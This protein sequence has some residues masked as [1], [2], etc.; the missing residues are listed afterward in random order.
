MLPALFFASLS[1]LCCLLLLYPYLVYPLL[2]AR[3]P[4]REVALRPV[5]LQFSLLFCVFNEKASIAGKI[6][7]LRELKART[8][9]LQILVYDDGSSDG[10]AEV[11]DQAKDVV[12]LVR[13]EGRRGK[14]AGMRRLA[15]LAVGEILVFTDA[16][17]L[18]RPDVIEC[19]APYYGDAG[20]GG[21]CGTL[22]YE[23]EEWSPTAEIGAHYW[24]IDERLRSLESATGN[25]MGADGSIFS[26]RRGLYPTFPD[27]VLD[28][29]VTSMSVVFAGKRL[30]KAPDVIA[31]EQS[32]ARADEEFR[33]KIRIG[34]R[35]AHTHRWMREHLRTMSRLDRFKYAS[36]KFLRWFGG[37][38]LAASIANSLV[39]IA[40][41]SV[42]ASAI[43]ALA[44]LLSLAIILT[45]KNGPLA[46]VGEIL[47]ALIATQIG[48]LRGMRGQTVVTWA[49]AV[50]R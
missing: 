41:V 35:A 36:R 42:L 17:V 21:V 11:L 31:F 3:Y 19:L 13:G 37:G 33:R 26:I 1:M 50:S 28:D 48:V 14:A 23:N 20:V 38:F 49:P 46:K 7:N 10:T 12:T 40:F 25:V 2:L 44:S 9:N 24:S 29:F 39:A 6:A 34:T 43:A 15:S 32:V 22:R 8:P 18:C 45:A 27:T 5:D 47:R 16:N 4:R 30:I